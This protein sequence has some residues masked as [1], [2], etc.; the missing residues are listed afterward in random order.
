MRQR[1]TFGHFLVAAQI[2][3][4]SFIFHSLIFSSTLHCWQGYLLATAHVPSLF[5]S[6]ALSQIITSLQI[7]FSIFFPKICHHLL[8]ELTDYSSFFLTVSKNLSKKVWL[9]LHSFQQ[10]LLLKLCPIPTAPSPLPSPHLKFVHLSGFSPRS[11][12]S[13]WTW[14]PQPEVIPPSSELL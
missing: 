14:P 12:L 9:T 1:R 2:F 5:P 4:L 8:Q 6:E 13:S 11:H 10:S 7:A 3:C